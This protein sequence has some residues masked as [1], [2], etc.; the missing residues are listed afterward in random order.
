MSDSDSPGAGHSR[1]GLLHLIDGLRYSLKG[2]KAAWV[3]AEAFRQELILFIAA[4]IAAVFLG[5][6]GLERAL[7]IAVLFP[8]LI[9][10]LINTAVETVV[11]R[12]GTEHHELSGRAKDLASAAVFISII[13]AVVT[14]LLVL[15][16]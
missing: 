11:D 14:W 1:S 10:E 9:A 4:V 16:G 2:L 8:I 12:V 7:L 6:N 15:L 13:G 5:D 3:H